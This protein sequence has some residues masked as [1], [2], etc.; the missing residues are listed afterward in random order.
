MTPLLLALA[1]SIGGSDPAGDPLKTLRKEHPRL[2]AL[3][4]DLERVR[5]M[6]RTAPQARAIYERLR[7]QAS[8]IQSAAPVQHVLIGPRLLAQSRRCLDRIYTLAL[9]YRLDGKPEYLKRALEE[10][11]AAA[12]FPDWNPSHF[13]DTAEMTHAFAIGYDWLY[14]ALSAED[15]AWIRSAIVEKGIRQA[16][17]FYERQRGWVVNRFNWNQ[18][19][20]GGIGLGALAIADEEPELCR[21]VISWALQSLPR[22]MASYAPDGGWPEGPG[23]WHYATRYNVYFLAGLETALGTDFSLS[24]M[25]GFAQA[26]RFRVYFSGPAEKT[27]NYADAGDAIGGAAEMFWLARKFREPVYAWHQQRRLESPKV[28]P[29]ALDLI[30]YQAE[31]LSP[32]QAGWPLDALFRGVEVAFLRSSWEDPDAIFV[33]VKAGD[34]KVGH[35]QLDLGTFVLDFGRTRWA[36]DLGADDYNLP[37]YFGKERWNY[38]RMRTESH[39]TVLIDNQ[40]Q[41]PKAEATIVAH[42]FRPELAMVRMDLSKAYPQCVSRWERGVALVARRYIVVQDE[43]EAPQPVEALWGMVTDA[44]VKTAGARAELRKPGWRLEGQVHHPSGAVFDVVST[45]PP[46]PQNPNRGT[47]KLVVRLPE[48]ITSLRLVV[49]LVPRR[50]GS[51]AARLEWKDRPLAEW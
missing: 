23:Y 24:Q 48:K 6:I 2:I 50:E 27:F 31:G 1:L 49:A 35:S 36:I 25:Q 3:P 43:I 34:L 32:Q 26:G 40:N 16:L 21:T 7:E 20:N 30:W 18:V 14:P 47:A 13:L 15:R 37:G 22:A 17:P 46:P 11:R 8:D 51:D 44:E 12:A 28:R 4:A 9:L 5:E 29:E 38:Y 39:N 33:G 42:R 19:C 10:L 41:D 45:T